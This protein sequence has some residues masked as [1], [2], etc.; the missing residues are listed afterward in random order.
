MV[1]PD[2]VGL[3]ANAR[4][5]LITR[6]LAEVTR[7]A[8]A[9]GANPLTMMGLAGMETLYLRVRAIC[10]AT[11]GSG[12]LWGA[13]QTLEEILDELGE[14]A[15]GVRT[16]K[17]AHHLAEQVGVEL[18]ITAEVHALLYEENRHLSPYRTSSGVV[19]VRS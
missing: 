17:S 3:G 7:L 8:V 5:A 1:Y 13:G 12:W 4:A 9:L 6:G 16:T 2:G 14:V 18:P 10:L 19:V 15:E 11:G